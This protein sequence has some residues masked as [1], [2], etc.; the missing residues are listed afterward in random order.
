MDSFADVFDSQVVLLVGAIAV[1][2]LLSRLL[3][4]V[5]SGGAGTILTVVVIVLLLQYVFGI[6]PKALW[7][8][9]SHLPQIVARWVQQLT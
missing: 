6:S 5:L 9:I 3:F 2:F 1:F 4:R 7:F 8:E